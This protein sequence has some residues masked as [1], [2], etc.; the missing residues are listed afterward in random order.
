MDYTKFI[1]NS[2]IEWNE[3]K[4]DLFEYLINI[5]QSK[6]ELIKLLEDKEQELFWR[7]VFVGD[8]SEIEYGNKTARI[9]QCGESQH[10]IHNYNLRMIN[11]FN[12]EI[13]L[14]NF[15]TTLSE[16]MIEKRRPYNEFVDI[17]NGFSKSYNPLADDDSGC[18][19]GIVSHLQQHLATFDNYLER[20]NMYKNMFDEISASEHKK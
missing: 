16:M 10:S 4:D 2:L 11:G 1:N 18:N 6:D 8:N 15:D 17:Y 9:V 19:N 5:I 14:F 12:Y 7:G 3:D 20:W 13:N